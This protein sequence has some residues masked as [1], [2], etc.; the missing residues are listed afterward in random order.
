LEFLPHALKWEKTTGIQVGKEE[1]KLFLFENDMIL[2]P[3]D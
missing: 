2:Y 1:F 3:K